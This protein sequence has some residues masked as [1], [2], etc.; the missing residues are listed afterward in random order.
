MKALGLWKSNPVVAAK[1]ADGDY[2]VE[3]G[4]LVPV[5]H[6]TPESSR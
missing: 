1:L 2:K 3:D 5:K 4:E 6:S